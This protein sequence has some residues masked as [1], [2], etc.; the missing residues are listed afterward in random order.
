MARWFVYILQCGDGTLYTGIATDV[1]RR[2]DEHRTGTGSKYVRGRMPIRIAYTEEHPDRAA[3]SKREYSIKRM[4]RHAK[5][6]I[7]G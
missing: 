6:A 4:T 1:A 3:A 7:I 5:L 2:L